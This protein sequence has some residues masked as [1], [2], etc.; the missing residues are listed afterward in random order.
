MIFEILY[1]I[2]I[3]PIELLIE[4]AYTFLSIVVRYNPVFPILGISL[5][6]SIFCLPL[7][8]KAEA[9]QNIE[10]AL[11][12]KMKPKIAKIKKY[13]KGN[14]KIMVLNN[15]YR[16]N[17][18]HPIMALRS[19][20]GLLIQIPFFIAAYHFLSNL[21]SLRGAGFYFIKDLG[22]PDGLLGINNS[23]INVLP[24][25][26]TLINILSGYIYAKEHELKEKL[27]L[28]AMAAVF[29][30]LL[31]NSPSALVLYWTFNN[32]FSLLKNIVYKTKN[33]IKV[34]YF[35]IIF[36]LLCACVFVLFFR[37][38]GRSGSLMFRFLAVGIS[39]II[40]GI[41]LYVK[42]VVNFG[43]K[44]FSFLIN[45]KQLI[46]Q[47]FLI[48]A[49]TLWILCGLFIPLNL[50]S[51]DVSSFSFLGKNSSPFS[52]I[53]PAA[54]IG[55]GLF[56]FWPVYIFYL[57]NY[58]TKV[59][60]TLISPVLLVFGIVNTFIFFGKTG[61]LSQTL[62]FSSRSVLNYSFSIISINLIVLL[63]ISFG[64]LFIFYKNKLKLLS[65]V[66][67]I[68]FVSSLFM[69]TWKIYSIQTD[70]KSYTAIRKIN[71]AQGIS[72]NNSLNK[73]EKIQPVFSLS[74]TGKNVVIIML[75][76]AIGSYLPLIF[77]ERPEL[78]EFFSGFTYYPNMISF[79]RATIMGTPPIFGG[80]EYTPE[81]LHARNTLSMADKNDESLLL[82]PLLFLENG[83]N[84]YVFDLPYVNYSDPMNISFFTDKGIHA[85]ILRNKY[86][87]KFQNEYPEKI[88]VLSID[89]DSI[90]KRNFVFFGLLTVSPPV[91]RS[92]IYRNGSYWSSKMTISDDNIMPGI[93]SEYSTLYYLPQITDYDDENGSLVLLTNHLTHVPSFL[94]Y[95]DYTVVSKITDFGP[96][97]FNGNVTSQKHYHVNA[98]S[99]LLLANWFSELRN[100]GVYDNTR[101]I[102]VSDHDELVVKPAFSGELNRINTFYHP[103]LLV[104]DFYAEGS[105]KIDN[106]FMTTADVPLIAM[107]DIIN[108]PK[109]LLPV[110]I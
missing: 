49:I 102:I 43:K 8:A 36:F 101:I 104:K 84:S 57:F 39:I 47:I 107:E 63:I 89:Y 45:Y 99:Y 41:P 61:T 53:Y 56:I 55:L 87:S 31:Y 13:F 80:Y 93:I 62:V 37:S 66:L 3:F 65:S 73:Q 32:I 1:N 103:V 46:K 42:F 50:V 96:E 34:F 27:Q 75:D 23:R 12:K 69:V 10:R 33:P 83:Y 48:S 108:N 26:M 85:D 72:P 90:L 28:I 64:I 100:N 30:I 5:L 14:E 106:S 71:E 35:I 60:M 81:G 98:A 110:T 92:V 67:M 18:Y 74:K 86:Y 6:V 59:I 2:I 79:F 24:I 76:R 54:C 58:K 95:P 52:L 25:V 9:V 94:Q 68:L 11:Q 105:L 15:Y 40:A 16:L 20:S 51:S 77:D 7:Y 21:E 82:M 109:I 44:H 4:T 17:N 29:L 70:Y 38:Q 91:L 22:S 97:R 88:P 19:T 78:N